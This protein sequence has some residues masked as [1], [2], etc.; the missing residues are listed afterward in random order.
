MTKDELLGY[1]WAK[2]VVEGAEISNRWIFLECK[3]YINRLEGADD[4]IWCQ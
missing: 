4:E 2:K 3:R 1:Q